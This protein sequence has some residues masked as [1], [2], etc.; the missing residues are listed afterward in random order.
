MSRRATNKFFSCNSFTLQKPFKKYSRLLVSG[1]VSLSH[2]P[3]SPV[4]SGGRQQSGTGAGAEP[5]NRLV[6]FRAPSSWLGPH[7]INSPSLRY[8]GVRVRAHPPLAR[9]PLSLLH[10]PPLCLARAPSFSSLI[11]L[12]SLCLPPLLFNSDLKGNSWF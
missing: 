10:V 5:P 4:C 2:P 9:A 7:R 12:W 6:R 11:S 1:G 3:S 8:V